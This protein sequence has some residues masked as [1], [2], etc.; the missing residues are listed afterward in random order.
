MIVRPLGVL[1]ND[2]LRSKIELIVKK[3]DF[4][5]FIFRSNIF[6]A[7][8]IKQHFIFTYKIFSLFGHLFNNDFFCNIYAHLTVF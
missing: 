4:L 3:F 5:P 6:R 2:T 7:V 1:S 8:I